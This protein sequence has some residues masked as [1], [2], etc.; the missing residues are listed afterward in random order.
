MP[1][2]PFLAAAALAAL[3]AAASSALQAADQAPRPNLVVILCDDLGYG[4]LS[5]FAHP[6]IR[7]PHLDQLASEGVRLT[8]C[9]AAAPV[10]SPSRGGLMTGRT[11]NRLGIRDWI[12]ADSGIFLQRREVTIAQLLRQAGYRT[13]HVGKWHLNSRVDG[14]EPTPGDAGFE[15]WLYTQNNVAPNH[16]DPTNFIRNGQRAGPQKGP[17]SH[18]VVEE[19]LQW[20]AGVE[21]QP[22]FL[23]VWFHE[24]HELVAA[25]EEF[26]ALYPDEANLDRRHY[27]GDVSQMDAAV[28]KLLT[29]LDDRK[30]RDNTF[31]FFSSDNGPETLNRYKTATRSYGSPGPLRGM[32]LHITE[33]GCRVPGIIRWPGRIPPGSVWAEPVCSLDLLPTACELAGIEPPR[34][35][36][37]DGT[38]LLPLLANQ[39][40]Q[41]SHPL[42]WQYDA[43][44]SQPWVIALRDGPWKLLANA[45]LDRFQLYRVA[46][47]I[48]E[49]RDLASQYPDR[50]QAL[51]RVAKR[52]HA[53][54]LAEGEASGNP[55]G[56]AQR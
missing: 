6:A 40:L 8:H 38:S 48:G 25:A 1:R 55:S 11:P 4:D 30:L 20:L 32:K 42:Y 43:A 9:Y 51:A 34:D 26:L 21:N 41:R 47:D 24:T 14:S 35:R 52:L 17:S 16:L 22:F 56:A 27:Y 19:A 31:V 13:C 12:P 49:D 53:E 54:I 46:D 33:A 10:C 44:I 45:T 28:G 18:V 15:H 23:N 7:S 50:V 37:L 3:L 2:F 29:Y 5:C 39:P 36:P